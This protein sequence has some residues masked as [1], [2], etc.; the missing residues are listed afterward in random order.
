MKERT[1]NK[2]DHNALGGGTATLEGVRV[3]Y[4]L[5]QRERFCTK[6]SPMPRSLFLGSA[7]KRVDLDLSVIIATL[8]P[9]SAG[10]VSLHEQLLFRRFSS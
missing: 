6:R 10:I 3:K 1:A 7:K 8:I 9:F 2:I 4:S 5:A